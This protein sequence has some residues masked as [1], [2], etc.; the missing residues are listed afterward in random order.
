MVGRGGLSWSLAYNGSADFAS[1]KE[2]LFAK[3]LRPQ[4]APARTTDGVSHLT[5]LALKKTPYG[6]LKVVGRGGFEP[7]Y[8]LVNR[9]TVCRL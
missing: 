7:P 1:K 9:F 4:L 5:P 3:V 6:V 2:L 8:T